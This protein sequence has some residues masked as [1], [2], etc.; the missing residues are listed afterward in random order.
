MSELCDRLLPPEPEAVAPDGSL[1]RLLCA[2]DQASMAHFELGPGEVSRPVVHR[3][4]EEIWFVLEGLGVMWRKH[5]SQL[6]YEVDLRPQV[7]LT[8]P[9]GT[10]FQ[11]KNTG[12]L[13]LAIVGVTI[14]PWPGDGEAMPGDGPWVPSVGS[15]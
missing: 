15:S 3:T 6:P 8:I 7:S 4:V 1:V 10:T 13:P 11:F 9:V 12:R 2:V 14:P 5:P